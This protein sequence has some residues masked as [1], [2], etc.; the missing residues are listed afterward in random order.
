MS[1]IFKIIGIIGLLLIIAGIFQ[2]NRKQEDLLFALGGV[3][4]LVYSINL[5]DVIFSILQIAFIISAIYNYFSLKKKTKK[6]K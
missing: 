2:K 6:K 4:L 5:K 3:F 1:F